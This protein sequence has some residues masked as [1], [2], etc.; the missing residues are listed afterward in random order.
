M[1]TSIGKCSYCKNKK[2]QLCKLIVVDTGA[3]DKLMCKKCEDKLNKEIDDTM[4]EIDRR[5][6][7]KC[8]KQTMTN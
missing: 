3:T 5:L 4:E 1:M 2:A 8:L 6:K 7:I